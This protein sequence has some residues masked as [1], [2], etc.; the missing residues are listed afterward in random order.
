MTM[1]NSKNIKNLRRQANLTQDQ[2]AERMGLSRNAIAQWESGKTSPTITN[3]DRLSKIFKTTVA[4]PNTQTATKNANNAQNPLLQEKLPILGYAQGNHIESANAARLPI[5]YV[6]KPHS[7]SNYTDLYA[8]YITGDSMSPQHQN[9]EIRIVSPHIPYGQGDTV[10]IVARN[11]D[12][13]IETSYIKNF[14]R[15]ETLKNGEELYIFSQ[16]NPPVD[17]NFYKKNL[18]FEH[19]VLTYKEVLGL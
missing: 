2:L 1:T 5:G 9:S 17:I 16:L 8:V 6:Q 19:K 4:T 11:P 18:V 12:T 3:L 10:I 15:I 14:E 13:N 7:L